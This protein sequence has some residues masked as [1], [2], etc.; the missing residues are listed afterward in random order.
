V[1]QRSKVGKEV[2]L[3]SEYANMFI[4][5]TCMLKKIIWN[6]IHMIALIDH[7]SCVVEK[8]KTTEPKLG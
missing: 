1:G 8:T 7:L 6:T 2:R 5:I 4:I 3:V